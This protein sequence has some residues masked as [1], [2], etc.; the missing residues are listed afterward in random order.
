MSERE[1]LSM[2]LMCE[3][4]NKL[5]DLA[6]VVVKLARNCV[7]QVE[8]RRL[9]AATE[10]LTKLA[11]LLE[12]LKNGSLPANDLDSI[13]TSLPSDGDGPLEFILRE[14]EQRRRR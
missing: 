5:A 13:G 8:I 11:G 6:S 4:E 7:G 1:K 10:E 2:E 9:Q 12:M 3:L 14:R